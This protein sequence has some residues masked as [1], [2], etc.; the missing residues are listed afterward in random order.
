MSVIKRLLPFAM[1][2]VVGVA[3]RG[4][5]STQHA[6]TPTPPVTPPVASPTTTGP[7]PLVVEAA[8][9]HTVLPTTA[10]ETFMLI[11]VT[12]VKQPQA[13]TVRPSLGLTLVIDRSGS[14]G[15][16]RKMETANDAA[17]KALQALHAGDRFVVVSF[18]NG[19]ERIAGGDATES[20]TTTACARIHELSA[21]GSTDM[22]SGLR[23]GGNEALQLTGTGRVSRLL[24]LSDGQPD[25]DVGL[26]ERAAELARRGVVTTT[27]GLGTDYN[28][29][30]MAGT[31]DA[32][33]G[34]NWFVESRAEQQPSDKATL[35]HIFS[36]E[37]NSMTDVVAR[38]TQLQVPAVH[39]LHVVEAIGYR[40][41]STK[42]TTSFIELGDVY[43][44]HTT[45]VLLRLRRDAH[46]A[47]ASA[48][49]LHVDVTG[50]VAATDAAFLTSTDG[51]AAFSADASAVEASRVLAVVEKV[52][53]YRTTQA[54]LTANEAWN[55][56]DQA[57]GDAILNAQKVQVQAS[58]A[59]LGSSKLQSLFS[60][61]DSYQQQNTIEGT[62]GRASMN[63][64]AKE[65]A[66][67]YQRSAR[68][69]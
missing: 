68:K 57:G 19:A 46:D 33:V 41:Q 2:G 36:T 3:A 47:S 67:D 35:A 37:L 38:S 18:D 40:I 43:A 7:A 26:R 32:G 29:D 12:G 21:R 28:E 23:V 58:A 51:V 34:N 54:L 64:R 14:M 69:Q 20:N 11:A 42:S 52:E 45:E 44:G 65:K 50:T 17:C 6:P 39:G 8:F 4:A 63:K 62:A 59:A 10:G 27:I 30:L 49:R 31:A 53:E 9:E 1:L 25:S 16:E 48:A 66:R 61:V 56:G 22:A 13:Q 60:D 55:R 5:V 24:L 15:A